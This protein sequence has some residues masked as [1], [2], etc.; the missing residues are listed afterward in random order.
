M[1]NVCRRPLLPLLEMRWRISRICRTML[2]FIT[3]KQAINHEDLVQIG[4]NNEATG[5]FYF[6]HLRK[7]LNINLIPVQL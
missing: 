4:C 1:P 5:V 3:D 7:N 6:F 2:P